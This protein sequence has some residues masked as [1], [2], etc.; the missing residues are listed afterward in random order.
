MSPFAD[1]HILGQVLFMD[2]PKRPQEI[3]QPGPDSFPGITVPFAH[4]IA[5]VVAGILAVRMTDRV[6][7]PARVTHMVVS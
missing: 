4:A 2:A 7:S 5:I 3:A 1:R 6:M